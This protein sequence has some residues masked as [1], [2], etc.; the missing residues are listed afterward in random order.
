M[1]LPN[2]L[3]HSVPIFRCQ[4]LESP[5]REDTIPHRRHQ[6]LISTKF[7]L[8]ERI[9]PSRIVPRTRSLSISNHSREFWKSRKRFPRRSN[10]ARHDG[11]KARGAERISDRG[12]VLSPI[13]RF[14][15]SAVRH[16]PRTVR[17]QVPRRCIDSI[18]WT[19][20]TSTYP[21]F[22]PS[23]Y[24]SRIDAFPL[25]SAYFRHHFPLFRYSAIPHH[26]DDPGIRLDRPLHFPSISPQVQPPS[27]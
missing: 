20:R 2:L 26:F 13:T 9:G 25:P 14:P 15:I 22:W 6:Q 11:E 7:L 24:V 18:F 16:R 8:Q 17:I 23:A 3:I 10:V 1:L 21:R 5:Q 19:A 27:H 12:Q 4:L